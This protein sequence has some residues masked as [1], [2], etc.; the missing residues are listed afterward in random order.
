MQVSTILDKIDEGAIALPEFQRG[1]VWGRR[2]VRELIE[3]LYRRF[4]VG[5]LLL[6][7]TATNGAPTRGDA[8][9][10]PG[11]VSLLLDGQQ[12]VTSLYGLIRGTPP[13]FFDGEASAFRDLRFHVERE[14]FQFY[15]PVTMRDD[16][17]WIDVSMLLR[18]GL[19]WAMSQLPSPGNLDPTHIER[20]NRL[21][22]V[23][24]ID[25]HAEEITGADKTVDVVVELFNK[26]N[27]AG[28]K[29]SKGDLTLAKLCASWPPA[30][31][32]LKE[33]L[34]KWQKAGF[35][36]SLD[37]FLRTVTAV[38]TGRSEFD[39]LAEEPVDRFRQG[40]ADGERAIDTV[41]NLV[42]TRLGLDHDRVLGG[43]GAVPLMSRFI[44]DRGFRLNEPE[45]ADRL[46]FW[47][48][49]ALL[50]GRYSGSTETVLNL[51]LQLITSDEPLDRLIGELRR[52]RGDLRVRPD[53]FIGQTVSARFYPLLYMLTRVRGARDLKSGFELRRHLLGKHSGLEVHHVFPK[54]LLYDHGY[55]RPER[56]A[57]ANF[58]FLTLDTNRALADQAPAA[59]LPEC[60]RRQPG[61]LAS[62]WIPADPDLWRV[63]RY[64]DF[65]AVRRELLADAA[66]ELLEELWGGTL[67]E[68]SASV[69]EQGPTS[70][71]AGD[72]E[73]AEIDRVKAWMSERGLSPGVEAFALL[74]LD[75]GR[76]EAVLDLAWPDGLRYGMERVALLLDEPPPVQEAAGRHGY[77]F[78]TSVPE[79]QQYAER[80]LLADAA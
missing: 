12:R 37:W 55:S 75:G 23:R 68:V 19:G 63:E 26:V 44:A 15:A 28:T 47:Y 5:S 70:V 72:E 25:L 21:Y 6:W 57:L 16:P 69:V 36:F 53:D 30:R 64:Q 27:S 54:A 8:S 45:A 39:A 73:A 33:R 59:Y 78:F 35:D 71:G 66:N 10:Q 31:D 52:Q 76:E 43:R 17:L 50:W 34:A 38:V 13:P 42:S 79:I 49:H 41:L 29:L 60:E 2:Q 7:Q 9:L 14:E 48:V 80:E 18:E 22:T 65:L 62:H 46:L 20:L 40:L 32:E 58:A 3:S 67:E 24:E 1:Y 61:V 56:N 11:Y 77:R 4:P 74:G 51:D